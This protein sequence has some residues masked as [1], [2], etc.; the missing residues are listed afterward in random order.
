MT[1]YIEYAFLE[2]LLL[3]GVLLWFAFR[4]AR[5]SVKGWRLCLAAAI[6]GAFAVVYPLLSLPTAL[7]ISLKLLVGALLPLLCMR[8]IRSAKEWGRYALSATFFFVSTFLFGGALLGVV[9]GLALTGLPFYGVAL[10]FAFLA[11]LGAV[12]MEK[13]YKRRAT[14]QYLYD[15]TLFFGENQSEGVGFS[16]SGNQAR[17]NGLPVC[18]LSAD[19]FYDLV[20]M[21][22]LLKEE[23]GGQVRDEMQI[24]TAT[25]ERT[26][27]LYRGE[28]GV[29]IGGR[30][31]KKEVYFACA[32]NRIWGEYKVIFPAW[33]LE[34]GYE[35]V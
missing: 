25:G 3:D 27:A 12:L 8:R 5:V 9:E 10:G 33:I 35:V 24:V 19:L 6:G 13:W 1:V 4:A 16:D 15:C 29:K 30:L 31:L 17:K 21:D 32:A 28:I 34:A 14:C 23:E 11:L 26:V 18:F 22:G 2:N 20:G 7:G